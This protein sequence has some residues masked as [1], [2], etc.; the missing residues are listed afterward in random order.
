MNIILVRDTGMHFN[1][2]ARSRL[3]L[4]HGVEQQEPAKYR[5][6]GSSRITRIVVELLALLSEKCFGGV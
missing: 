5:L 4:A 3:M 1:P 2:L 6:F